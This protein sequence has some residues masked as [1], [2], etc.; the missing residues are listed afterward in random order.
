MQ[1]VQ[2]FITCLIDSLFPQVGE[3]VIDI[4]EDAG[5][6]VEFPEGQTCCGQP[7]FNAGYWTD[8]G[9]MAIRMLDVFSDTQGPIII[10]SGSCGDMVKHRYLE[11]FTD[12]PYNYKRALALS[13]RIYEFSEFLV[14]FLH[15]KSPDVSLGGSIAYHPSCH[16]YRGMGI[17]RQPRVLLNHIQEQIHYL[18]PD[19]C[20]FG[21]VFSVDYPEL[22]TELLKRKMNAIA[23]SKATYV[24]AGDVSCLMHIEG[25]LR[26]IGSKVRCLHISQ[27]LLGRTE[28]LSEE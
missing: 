14:D 5:L 27:A 19:C 23:E 6:D 12:D 15:Y 10:P 4:L 25:G 28:G 7:A 2:L 11:L 17:D 20:G 21:G 24:V 3:A 1:T 26:R 9:S 13:K 22:S 18:E 16:L 8:A